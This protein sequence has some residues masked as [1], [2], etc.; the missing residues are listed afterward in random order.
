MKMDEK[1]VLGELN[2]V[3]AIISDT[4]IVY[5]S[6]KHGTRYMNKD[7]LYPHVGLTSRLCRE[8]ALEISDYFLGEPSIEAVVAPAIGGVILCTWV[9]YWLSELTGKEVLALYAE[10]NQALD[11]FEFNRGYGRLV[12][13]WRILVLEDVL[14]TGGSAKKVIGAVR[15]LGGNVIGVAAQCNRGGV[16]TKDLADPPMLFSLVNITMEA[17]AG[18][19]CPM[20][21]AGIPINTEVGKGK[22]FLASQVH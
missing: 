12:T 17:W 2:R 8:I 11:L 9:A 1:E 4:H 20:C 7:A 15:A 22:E 14:T 21:K 16:T 10:K 13:G 5:T 19:D 6:G 3:G 18:E